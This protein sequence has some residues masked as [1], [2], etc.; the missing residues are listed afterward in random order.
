MEG[1]AGWKQYAIGGVAGVLVV[2]LLGAAVLV[3]MSLDAG[4]G[5][6]RQP[7]AASPPA[8]QTS[9]PQDAEVDPTLDE[10][11]PAFS[12]PEINDTLTCDYLLGDSSDFDDYRF[13]AG[14]AVTNNGGVGAVVRVRATW[15][16]LGEKPVKISRKFRVKAFEEREWQV[17]VPATPDQIDAH[18]SAEGE[19]D[20]S[21]KL[22]DTFGGGQ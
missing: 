17:K 9:E 8:E 1:G 4:P 18:Q 5:S 11:D 21:A 14:G 6:S 15:K 19:C 3:G 12:E 20:T 13:V 2:V 22:I 10:P 7:D 16:L